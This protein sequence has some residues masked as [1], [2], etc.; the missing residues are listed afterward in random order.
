M[1][2]FTIDVDDQFDKLLA[3]LAAQKGSSKASV[4]RDAVASYAYLKK[5]QQGGRTVS[6]TEGDVI[7]KDVVLP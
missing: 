4:V 7:V 3:E 2:R 5:E 6:V 1:S